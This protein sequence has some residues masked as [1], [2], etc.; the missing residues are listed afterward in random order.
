MYRD[1]P[2]GTDY[3]RSGSEL[4]LVS[5]SPQMGQSQRQSETDGELRL[6]PTASA[7][8]PPTNGGGEYVCSRRCADG[9][10]CMITVSLPFISCH[11]HDQSN[12][13]VVDE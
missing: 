13:V 8:E 4:T 6:Q 12:P 11:Q 5:Y 2:I 3:R 10:R 1:G 7:D 9:T